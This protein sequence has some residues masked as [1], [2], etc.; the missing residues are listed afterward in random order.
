MK[1][2]VKAYI[3]FFPHIH[4]LV[5]KIQYIASDMCSVNLAHPGLGKTV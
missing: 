3:L 4:M 1:Y 5:Q 2:F